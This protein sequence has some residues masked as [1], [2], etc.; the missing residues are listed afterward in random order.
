MNIKYAANRDFLKAN[1]TPHALCLHDN[2]SVL[3]TQNNFPL[4]CL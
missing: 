3:R 1:K 4:K 2:N